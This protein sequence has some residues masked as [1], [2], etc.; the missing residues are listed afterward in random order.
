MEEPARLAGWLVLVTITIALAYVTRWTEG[1]PDRQVLYEWST[2][3]GGIVQDGIILAAVLLI[4]H[5]RPSLLA[6]RRPVSSL[7]AL[8]FVGIAIVTIYVFEIVY[9]SLAH[10]GN[11]QGL[12][13][14]HWEPAHAAA[15]VGNGV[16]IC[17]LI[18]FVE[19]LTFRGV[20]YS[21]L[22]PDGGMALFCT[23]YTLGLLGLRDG[24]WKFIHELESGRSQLYDLE[25]DPGEE[26]DVAG[27]NGVRVEAY[28]DHLLRWAAA[29]KYRAMKGNR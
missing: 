26:R 8:A 11:E 9:S 14:A 24:R 7:N 6:L 19:E 28:R 18:P 10:P 12:T 2:A 13:P 22:E 21:L 15:Y 17:T 20:G 29:Q 16:V 27:D 1:K 3:I 4:A 5:G 25:T 23:D